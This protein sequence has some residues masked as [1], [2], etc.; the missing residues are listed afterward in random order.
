MPED[1]ESAL[2]FEQPRRLLR[3]S[4]TLVEDM[5]TAKA[6]VPAEETLLPVSPPNIDT[7]PLPVSRPSAA[8]AVS[9]PLQQS[10]LT[11]PTRLGRDAASAHVLIEECRKLCL[12]LF[13]ASTLLYGA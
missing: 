6:E 7:A 11:P 1:I 4:R 5:P 10:S 12:S 2:K 3:R 8:N 9:V 13:F